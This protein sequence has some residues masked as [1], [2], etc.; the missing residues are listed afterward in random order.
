MTT[1]STPALVEFTRS[2]WSPIQALGGRCLTSVIISTE[3]YGSGG[4]G[5][6]DADSNVN[7]YCVDD[8]VGNADG[9]VGG[10]TNDD[11]VGDGGRCWW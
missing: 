4:S 11:E 5:N 3:W 6:D 8:C 7:G 2:I 10:D 9:D 1:W